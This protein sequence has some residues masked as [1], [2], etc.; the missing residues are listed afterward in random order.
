MKL[1]HRHPPDSQPIPSARPRP[2]S[3][4]RQKP[5]RIL[6]EMKAKSLYNRGNEVLPRLVEPFLR[7]IDLTCGKTL[8]R[9]RRSSAFIK[10]VTFPWP[11]FS[12][13]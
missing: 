4:A 9:R 5:R 1:S 7:Y 3:Q 12:F 8:E 11:P 13:V 10:I 6:P 2:P